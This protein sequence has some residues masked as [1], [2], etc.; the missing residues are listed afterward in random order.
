M[1]NHTCEYQESILDTVR[2]QI[3]S[4]C[5]NSQSLYFV[6]AVNKL[7]CLKC[8]HRQTPNPETIEIRKRLLAN[9]PQ[10]EIQNKRESGE[11]LALVTQYCHKC[12]FYQSDTHVCDSCDCIAFDAIEELAI[13]ATFNCPMR[14]W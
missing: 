2:Q 6:T 9:F 14:I 8:L 7:V 12:K 5:V 10:T 3:V 1:R 4:R 13:D 11:V